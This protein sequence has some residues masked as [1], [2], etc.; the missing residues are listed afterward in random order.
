[1]TKPGRPLSIVF[2]YLFLLLPA[3]VFAQEK[4]TIN[5]VPDPKAHA[6]GNYVSNPDGV[7]NDGTVASVN[8]YL[9]QLEDSTTDQVAVVVL[10]SIGKQEPRSF[11]TELLRR[12]G[13]GQQG[14]N[15]GVLILLVMDQRR[16]EFEVGYGLEGKLT[17]LVPK[18]IQE[19]YM[20][21]Y[22]K[23]GDYDAA[24]LNGVEQ[25]CEVLLGNAV[26]DEQ[27]TGEVYGRSPVAP[28]AGYTE[29]V[30]SAPAATDLFDLYRR[31]VGFGGFWML[32]FYGIFLVAGLI[33]VFKSKDKNNFFFSARP[34]WF[35]FLQF[36][37]TYVLFA[38]IVFVIAG[39]KIN[40]FTGLA[41]F[42]LYGV[43][44]LSST[45]YWLLYRLK[46]EER[47]RTEY[48]LLY[49]YA[50]QLDQRWKQ[51]V[52]GKLFPF[53]L[54]N[55]RVTVGQ[56]LARLKQGMVISHT[57]SK[58]RLLDEKQ[59]DAY[60]TKA[61]KL[62]EQLKSVD[63][64]VWAEQ[65][66]KE[67]KLHGVLLSSKYSHCP[68]CNTMAYCLKSDTTIQSATYSRSGIGLK[69][70]ECKY[71]GY[72]EKKE[73]TIPKKSNSSSSGSSG[74]SWSSGSS[75]SSGSSWGGGSS[76]GGGAGSS[77]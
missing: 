6:S 37:C 2:F 58:M 35:S 36:L 19:V 77:W 25:V 57:G 70:Y 55:Y 14:R 18:Q 69:V 21:P 12:W 51:S 50:R 1:M 48:D 73:Y 32:L 68:K 31:H 43:G 33:N 26:A 46:L 3:S 5:N 56:Y 74:G 52:A 60:L 23:K 42:Y 44:Y 47:K 8:A 30:S 62:E 59:D 11:A 17:D 63:Y 38:V 54:R 76:G 67:F 16:M 29:L 13:I 27:K 34:W 49:L 53:P 71:C 10:N 15:N 66:S 41:F 45:V 22:A 75:S 61:Q 7:L 72:Q 39:I 64:D 40:F 24:V 4:W 28:G 65:G 20:V 9:K